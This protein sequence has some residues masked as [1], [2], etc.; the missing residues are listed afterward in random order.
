VENRYFGQSCL[1]SPVVESIVV[2]VFERSRSSGNVASGNKGEGD[3]FLK[4]AVICHRYL[5]ICTFGL[6]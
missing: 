3:H 1:V 5:T 6:Q 2:I 4:M